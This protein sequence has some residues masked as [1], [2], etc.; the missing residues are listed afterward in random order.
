MTASIIA[1]P[2]A[3]RR[4]EVELERAGGNPLEQA[5][6]LAR[7][8]AASIVAGAPRAGIVEERERLARL[9]GRLAGSHP[10]AVNDEAIIPFGAATIYWPLRGVP[11]MLAGL[12]RGA[13]G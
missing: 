5:I 10:L 11:E 8:I 3:E 9:V 12:A 1:F 4:A 13:A 6:G 2:T 7:A